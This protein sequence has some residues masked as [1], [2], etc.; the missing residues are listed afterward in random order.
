MLSVNVVYGL[1]EATGEVLFDE[2]FDEALESFS[3]VFHLK[4]HEAGSA[5]IKFS[6]NSKGIVG[7]DKRKYVLDLANSHP[8]D[9]QFARKYY[10]NVPESQRYPHRQTLVR[11]ELVDKWWASKL[12]GSDLTFEKAF[13]EKSFAFNP[14]AYIREGVEDPLVEEVSSYLTN[15]VLPSFAKD[16][17]IGNL[18]APYDGDHLTDSMHKM[19]STC[20]TSAS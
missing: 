2:E 7:S 8:L 20:G 5:K 18:T 10:D 17:A 15:E 6:S 12:E 3:K 4:N 9:S 16:Y 11:N 13:D 19:V 14:D 1:D